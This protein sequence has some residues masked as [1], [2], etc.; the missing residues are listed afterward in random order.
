MELINRL[1]IFL[2][3]FVVYAIVS[4][5]ALNLIL[6][7]QM[8]ATPADVS[9]ILAYLMLTVLL[10][11]GYWFALPFLIKTFIKVMKLKV[12]ISNRS[13]QAVL[14]MLKDDEI[15]FQTNDG[16][17]NITAGEDQVKTGSDI[18]SLLLFL[19]NRK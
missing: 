18:K 3:S 13:H 7:E 15:L 16:V 8:N 1:I 5:V 11:I 10:M 19:E 2:L 9:L 4:I 12:P 14:K 6:P 17:W